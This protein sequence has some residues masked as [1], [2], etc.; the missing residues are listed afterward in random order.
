MPG[1]RRRKVRGKGEK[2]KAKGALDGIFPSAPF[3][4]RPS[5]FPGR[6]AVKLLPHPQPPLA[7]GLV[8][9]NPLPCIELT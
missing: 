4:F 3:A 5:L 8:N 7:F 1:W 2:G 6:Q 9:V